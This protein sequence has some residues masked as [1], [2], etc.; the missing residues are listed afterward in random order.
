[1][2]HQQLLN[3]QNIILK[4][5]DGKV[6]L[7]EHMTG[8]WLLPGGK[9]NKKEGWLDGLRR[10]VEEETGIKDFS[11]ERIID[12]DSWVDEEQG[13]YI[14]TFLGSV[15]G[16]LEIVLSDEHK[17]YAWAGE[18]DLESYEFWNEKIRKRVCKIFKAHKKEEK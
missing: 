10:E 18:N 12:V 17:S 2:S 1:M 11:I 8:K 13:Y 4:N 3:P 15:S 7:L 5:R 6:L 14:V 9:I 16:N